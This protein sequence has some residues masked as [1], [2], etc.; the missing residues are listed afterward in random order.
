MRRNAFAVAEREH[1]PLAIA[2]GSRGPG[3][4]PD[5]CR[6]GAWGSRA[7]GFRLPVRGGAPQAAGSRHTASGRRLH[8]SRAQTGVESFATH[9]RLTVNLPYG[10]STTSAA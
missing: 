4:G 6:P 2:W 10:I 8:S 5:A 1:R 9:V 7:C 3:C